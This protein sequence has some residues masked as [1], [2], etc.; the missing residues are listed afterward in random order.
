MNPIHP[1][2]LSV[3]DEQTAVDFLKSLFVH[4]L[5]H[6]PDDATADCLFDKGLSD[7]QLSG[8]QANMTATFD[9]VDPSAVLLELMDA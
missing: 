1:A 4:G 9:F 5:A 7:E 8:I 3:T 6:H 2:D